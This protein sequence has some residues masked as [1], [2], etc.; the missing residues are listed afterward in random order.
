[1]S[2]GQRA[3][4]LIVGAW[5]MILNSVVRATEAVDILIAG[6]RKNSRWQGAGGRALMCGSY[7]RLEIDD[8]HA[9][10]LARP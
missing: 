1:M 6:N 2:R 8:T 9:R 3:E 4:Y 5:A 7:D 10:P